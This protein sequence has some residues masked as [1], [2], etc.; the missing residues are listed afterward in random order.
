[1]N[2]FRANFLVGVLTILLLSKVEAYER[3]QHTVAGAQANSCNVYIHTLPEATGLP[4]VIFLAGTGI[5]STGDIVEG[6]PVVQTLIDQKKA[7][8]LSIDKPGIS[9]SENS[10]EHFIIDNAAYNL[11]TQR[12]L[13]ECVINALT[14]ASSIQFTSSL[15]DV[16]FLGHSEGTQVAIRVYQRLLA[17][18]ETTAKRVKGLF[19]S[20]LVMNTWTDII[21]SQIIDP[22]QNEEF[23]NAYKKHDDVILRNYGDLAYAY[24]QDIFSTE[25]NQVTLQSLAQIAPGAFFE[26]YHGLNDENTFAK[27]VMEFEKWNKERRKQSL[28]TLSFQARY[29]QAGHNLNLAALNDMIFAFLAYLNP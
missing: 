27:P 14:W 29:Y 26:I 20:G 13:I 4:L 1:M 8:V 7:V 11:Y 21:N 15:S 18:N 17:E 25:A 16:Y 3:I 6:N 28:P 24:W 12:D 23:W 19:L 10:P 9:Y 22:K 5:Y 2:L